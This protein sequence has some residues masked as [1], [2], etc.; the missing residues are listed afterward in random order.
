[1]KRLFAAALAILTLSFAGA[2]VANAAST[3]VEAGL[4]G[5]FTT[6][7]ADGL[8]Y[9]VALGKDYG[10]LRLEGE[11]VGSRTINGD[12]IGKVNSNL[13]NVNLYVQPFKLGPVTPFVNA[14]VGYGDIEDKSTQ[15]GLI[16]NVGAGASLPLSPHWAAVGRYR[17]FLAE[18]V[19]FGAT[20][21]ATEQ[22]RAQIATLGLRYTF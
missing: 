15:S 3:Y 11:Y 12:A 7:H 22:Y 16:F 19:K 14:G 21:T 10:A 8:A 18:D 17:V 5:S 1:M 13:G 9:S 20:P 6:G 4:G 2:S